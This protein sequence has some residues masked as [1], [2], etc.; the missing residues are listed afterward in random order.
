MI[1]L[2]STV[3]IGEVTGERFEIVP[4]DYDGHVRIVY[5]VDV[6]KVYKGVSI[7]NTSSK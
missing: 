6:T 7:N 1:L 2:F 3:V 4:N 5:D